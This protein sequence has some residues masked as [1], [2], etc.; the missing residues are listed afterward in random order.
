MDPTSL[1]AFYHAALLQNF[2]E[3]A[4]RAN[5]TQSGIS[6][7]IARLEEDLGTQL[8][9]RIGKKV[10]VTESGKKLLAYAEKYLDDI[11][12]L[13]ETLSSADTN[14]AGT[15]SYAMPASCLF[16]PHFPMLLEER[17]KKF[18]DLVIDLKL[19]TNEKAI[20]SLLAGDIDFGFT[21]V[22]PR[23]PS[24]DARHFA[25][26]EYILVGGT[27]KAN[28][29]LAVDDVAELGFI[30][31][32]GFSTLFEFWRQAHFPKLKKLTPTNLNY[33]G[34]VNSIHAAITMVEHRLGVSIF[35]RHCV[36]NTMKASKI[37]ECRGAPTMP[38]TNKIYIVTLKDRILPRRVRVVIDTFWKMKGLDA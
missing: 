5:L 10:Q 16:T 1:K 32:P 12:E 6:Q 31:Y 36:E 37:H 21:T 18:P 3:A 25:T 17:K 13:L 2:T 24:V 15:V 26:E 28:H 4:R 30:D 20:A 27:E 8:F 14:I 29:R 22:D 9:V 34:K 23:N 33:V 35:P 38:P 19:V 7:H 11:D